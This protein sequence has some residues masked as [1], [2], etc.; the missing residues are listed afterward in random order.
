MNRGVTTVWRLGGSSRKDERL[1]AGVS[2]KTEPWS[3]GTNHVGT[4]QVAEI[5]KLRES[6]AMET[7]LLDQS[8]QSLRKAHTAS[9]AYDPYAH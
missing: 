4:R 5:K 8:V 6:R 9:C 1:D 2:W 7:H 3:K